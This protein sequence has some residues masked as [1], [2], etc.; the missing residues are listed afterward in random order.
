MTL[1]KLLKSNNYSIILMF[2]QFFKYYKHLINSFSYS[3]S[4]LDLKHVWALKVMNTYSH[5]WPTFMKR[6]QHN[7]WRSTSKIPVTF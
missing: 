1:Y 3:S 4:S 5:V 6:L 7:C 2:L